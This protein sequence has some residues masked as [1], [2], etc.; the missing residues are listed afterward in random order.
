MAGE[1]DVWSKL[2]ALTPARV[3]LDRSGDA[4][5]LR[6]VLDFQ[7]AHAHARDAIHTAFDAAAIAEALKP[8]ETLSVES[9]AGDRA[10]Y[11][12]RPDL[13]RRL[14]EASAPRIPRLDCDVA[15]VV[16][17][18]LSATGVE[19]HAA[20]VLDAVMP[21]IPSLTVGPVV[22]ASQARVAIADE[23]GERMG[24]RISA[25]LIGERPGLSVSD[26]LGIYVT[27]GPR[28]GRSDAERNC[29]SNIHG[30][31]LTPRRA[32]ETLAWLLHQALDRGL[33]GVRLK[34]E[35]G[36]GPRLVGG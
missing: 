21:L 24:A 12:K 17:D 3:A 31:G 22:I 36:G 19:S 35:S 30:H 18:G 29:I 8:R 10:T 7:L 14:S 13:G 4:P 34:D 11:L 9:R 2:R 28:I 15:F 16:A 1:V 33:S 6:S 25:I 23:I 5:S 32:A 27:Y 26:S 20:A